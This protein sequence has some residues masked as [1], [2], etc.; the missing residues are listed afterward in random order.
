MPQLPHTSHPQTTLSPG[1]Q[2]LGHQ[3]DG[4]QMQASPGLLVAEGL[5]RGAGCTRVVALTDFWF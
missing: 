4:E 5:W 3:D 2:G 1:G